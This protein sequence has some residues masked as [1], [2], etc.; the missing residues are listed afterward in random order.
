VADLKAPSA[1]K[2]TYWP[3]FVVGLFIGGVFFVLIVSVLRAV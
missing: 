1:G 2:G 3:G